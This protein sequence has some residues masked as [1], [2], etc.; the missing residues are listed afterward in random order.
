MYAIRSY[1][2]VAVD[3][4]FRSRAHALLHADQ[5]TRVFGSVSIVVGLFSI[6]VQ[7]LLSGPL[8]RHAGLRS[9]L[10]IIVGV[11]TSYSIHYTKLYELASPSSVRMGLAMVLPLNAPMLTIW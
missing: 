3:F 4:L 9:Y 7:L 1:Y 11:I 10:L 5:L 2:A 6:A 8:L